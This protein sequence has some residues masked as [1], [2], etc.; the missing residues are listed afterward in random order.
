MISDLY[1]GVLNPALFIE[2]PISFGG[3]VVRF[4]VS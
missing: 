4:H 3:Y 1:M 2:N